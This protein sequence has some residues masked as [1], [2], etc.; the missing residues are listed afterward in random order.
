MIARIRAQSKETE[1]Q[2]KQLGSSHLELVLMRA[3]KTQEAESTEELINELRAE[4]TGA[5]LNLPNLQSKISRFERQLKSRQE[6][7]DR[8]SE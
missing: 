4:V 8:M 6:Q 2:L 1:L 5:S 7:V 3:V